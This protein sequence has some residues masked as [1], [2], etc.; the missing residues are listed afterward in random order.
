MSL[1]ALG[2]DL[3]AELGWPLLQLLN[4]R[5]P[6]TGWA[7]QWDTQLGFNLLAFLV[8]EITLDQLL[9]AQLLKRNPCSFL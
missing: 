4:C 9:G 2:C 7:T 5:V 6:L 1:F 3:N 8:C